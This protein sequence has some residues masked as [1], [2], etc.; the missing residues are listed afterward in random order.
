[1]NPETY[2]P[3]E[4]ERL[5]RLGQARPSA[6]VEARIVR[7]AFARMD[8]RSSRRWLPALVATA[9]TATAALAFLAT[10]PAPDGPA[11]AAIGEGSALV[12]DAEPRAFAL[13]GHRI[14]VGPA[15]RVLVER[16]AGKAVN[17]RLERGEASFEVEPLSGGE[18]FRVA[19]GHATVEVVGTRFT[20][21]DDGAC[22]QVSVARGKV[23]AGGT[24]GEAKL[25]GAGESARFCAGAAVAGPA[26]AA[27]PGEAQ[28]REAIRL[29]AEGR[30]LPRAAALLGQYRQEFPDG[31]FQEEALFHL[32]RIEAQ[33]G[34]ADEAAKLAD[35]FVARFPASAR[36]GRIRQWC[37]PDR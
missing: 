2:E 25:L 21:R 24:D 7:G 5:R 33:L 18:R 6:A 30:E 35:E 15:S 9:A 10:R 28:V 16:V 17:L 1:M 4:P 13:A 27:L 31:V 34:R 14:E 11:V 37:T 32:C 19:T 3:L 29:L 8:R 22:T 26:T 12:A 23:R 20:V 36:A